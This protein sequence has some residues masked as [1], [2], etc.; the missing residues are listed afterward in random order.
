[1]EVGVSDPEFGL[2]VTGKSLRD[3]AE[4]IVES[5]KGSHEPTAYDYCPCCGYDGL[6]YGDREKAIEDVLQMLCDALK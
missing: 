2:I 1:V 6:W 4:R 5:K 3:L